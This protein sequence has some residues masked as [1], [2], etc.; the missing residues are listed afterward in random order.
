MKFVQQYTVKW[1]EKYDK[2][3]HNLSS[4]ENVDSDFDFISIKHV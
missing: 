4:T 2:N 3:E 1:K